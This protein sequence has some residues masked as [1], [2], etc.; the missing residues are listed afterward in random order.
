MS[1]RYIK[2]EDFNYFFKTEPRQLSV[3]DSLSW[4]DNFGH[5]VDGQGGIVLRTLTEEVRRLN[6]VIHARKLQDAADTSEGQAAGGISC[7]SGFELAD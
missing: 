6:R 2:A 3:Y 5:T 7:L 1:S 4:S